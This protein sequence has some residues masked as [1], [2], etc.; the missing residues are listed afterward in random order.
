MRTLDRGALRRE[1][2]RRTAKR[3][4]MGHSMRDHA[5]MARR[6]LRTKDYPEEDRRRLGEAV[7]DARIAA[8]YRFRTDFARARGI[9]NVRGLELLENGKTGVGQAFLFEVADALPGWTHDTPGQILEGNPAPANESSAEDSTP[10]PRSR[11]RPEVPNKGD[12]TE[13][14][15]EFMW[16]LAR[17]G[18]KAETI[19]EEVRKRRARI[20]MR[21]E[22]ELG[23]VGENGA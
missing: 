1:R 8:G 16:A 20:Q 13:H 7:Q 9:K 22:T 6:Q 2:G 12:L 21:S 19:E 5:R 14:E 23:Q 3:L 4:A 17:S 15:L 18:L 11:P 10:T